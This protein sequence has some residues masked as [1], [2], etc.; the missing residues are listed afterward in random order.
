MSVE[1]NQTIAQAS[2]DNLH[3]IIVPDAVGFFP[4]APG[5]LI[6]LLLA[7][8]LLFH[9][10]FKAYACYQRSLYKREALNELERYT[11]KRRDEILA[12]LTLA[13][14]VGIAA[15]GRTEVA[16]LSGESWWDFMEQHSKVKIDGGLRAGLSDILYDESTQIEISDHTDVKELVSIWIKTHKVADHA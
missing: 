13:K 15:Y 3:D 4:L 12:L 1:L 7:L 9:V 14:R 8:S 16:K 5:W 6:V 11:D 10:V 2:L